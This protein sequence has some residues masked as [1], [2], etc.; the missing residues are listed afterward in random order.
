M[1]LVSDVRT[2]LDETSGGT[3][4]TDDHVYDAINQEL[5]RAYFK[6]R[7][8][9]ITS[10]DMN[11]W[12][13]NEFAALPQTIAIPRYITYAGK[14]YWPSSYEE[15]ERYEQKW[16]GATAGQPK[17]FIVWDHRFFRVWPEPDAD[18]TVQVWGIPWPT[19]IGASV[20]DISEPRIF[21]EMVALRAAANLLRSTMPQL[22]I[23]YQNEAKR[24][25][26]VWKRHVRNSK[27]LERMWRM[28]PGTRFTVSQH[29]NPNIWKGWT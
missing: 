22:S 3:F 19:E 4:W 8:A 25:E 23:A 26:H 7:G 24:L 14:E 9:R 17:A 13:G 5:L 18:Y 16:M 2:L 10:A 15:L 21:K 6:E 29:G 12:T 11:C 20:Q 1:S 27:G 28:R